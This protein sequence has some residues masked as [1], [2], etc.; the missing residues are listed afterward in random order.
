MVRVIVSV[1]LTKILTIRITKKLNGV[2]MNPYKPPSSSEDVKFNWK[3]L[4]FHV[5]GFFVIAQVVFL[6]LVVL[7]AIVRWLG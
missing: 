1:H 7:G 6:Y 2:K 5:L 3:S 4:V